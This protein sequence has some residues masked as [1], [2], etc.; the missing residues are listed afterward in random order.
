MDSIFGCTTT[1]ERVFV[2]VT[3]DGLYRTIDSGESWSKVL[4]RDIRSVTVDSTDDKVIYSDV[5]P[6]AT[7]AKTAVQNAQVL[8][9]R[10][11]RIGFNGFAGLNVLNNL[12]H[13]PE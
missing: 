1:S 12:N 7:A 3:H 8:H 5:E 4:A 11:R 10:L 9:R 2:G 13:S 6:V